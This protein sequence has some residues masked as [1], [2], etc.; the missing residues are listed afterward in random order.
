MSIP[1]Q[2]VQRTMKQSVSVLWPC[3]VLGLA[4]AAS[5]QTMVSGNISGTWSPSGNP[6]VVTDNATVPAGQTLT[7]QPGVTVWIAENVSITANGLIQAVGTPTQRITFQAPIASQYWSNIYCLHA[8]GT[9]RFKYCDFRNADTPGI[10]AKA[11][12]QP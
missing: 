8:S 1:V 11:E 7:I 5:A 4:S 6:Y 10:S 2:R 9:N 3:A 12:S